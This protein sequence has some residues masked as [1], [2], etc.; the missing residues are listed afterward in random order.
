L[1]AAIGIEPMNKADPVKEATT[2]AM[3]GNTALNI[4][5]WNGSA[6]VN[7]ASA[8]VTGNNKVWREFDVT[9][10]NLTGSKIAIDI[11]GNQNNDFARLCELQVRG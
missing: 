8:S 9:S 10:E 3:Y 1:E 5:R 2:N 11:L 4:E 6:W 7:I